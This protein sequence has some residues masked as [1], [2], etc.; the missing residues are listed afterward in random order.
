MACILVVD[1]IPGVR[2]S[3]AAGLKRLGH[4]VLEAGNGREALDLATGRATD[5]VITDMLM[6]EM[7]GVDLIDLL[8]EAPGK[9]PRILAMSGGGTFVTSQDALTVARQN[10][11]AVLE[12]PFDTVELC[13]A[14]QSLLEK[15]A[16]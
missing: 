1:D 2:K 12:K 3:I 15:G 16:T 6:P 9:T 11:D 14:V 4:E 10:A 5:L 8:N 13:D 7:D